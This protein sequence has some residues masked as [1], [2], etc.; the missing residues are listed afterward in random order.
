VF[1]HPAQVVLL[2]LLAAGVLA[3]SDQRLGTPASVL[4]PRWTEVFPFGEPDLL[5]HPTLNEVGRQQRSIGLFSFVDTCCNL[6]GVRFEEVLNYRPEDREPGIASRWGW[7]Y[8]RSVD[9]LHELLQV[10]IAARTAEFNGKA[11]TQLEGAWGSLKTQLEM[12]TPS[13]EIR[14]ADRWKTEEHLQVPV[15]G[16][17]YLFG[18][19]QAGYDTWTAQQMGLSSRT[20]IGCK[21]RP[22]RGGEIVLSGCKALSYAEDPLRP[23]RLPKEQSQMV[24]ELQCKYLLFGPLRLEYQGAAMPALDPLDHN[25]VQHDLRFAVPLGE[26]G[27]FHLGAK[28]QWEDT[29]VAK[30][31]TDGMQLYFG[32]GLKR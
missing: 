24:L 20:G 5:A 21:L 28:Q 30:P 26:S 13:S 6:Y 19:F 18:Q 8:D 15:A 25:R 7:A 4:F 12:E 22:I 2:G 31:W 23:V 29:G 17:V 9:W 32:V 27:H 1:T 3:P 16:P 11:G 14:N 10:E